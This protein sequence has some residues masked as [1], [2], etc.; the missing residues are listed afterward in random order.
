L[1]GL[2]PID[3]GVELR[4]VDGEG[5][6]HASETR[7]LVTLAD[8]ALNILVEG[9]V[10]EVGAVLDKQFEP[11]D[12]AEAHH[13]WRRHR[14]NEGVLDRGKLAV[15]RARDGRTAEIG[16]LAFFKRRQAK[17]NDARVWSDAEAANA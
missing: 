6:K 4:D 8:Y 15:Q 1:L 3:I 9:V 14:Q 10:T 12:G 11:A 2:D 16:S 17:E 7:G 13:G 5:G